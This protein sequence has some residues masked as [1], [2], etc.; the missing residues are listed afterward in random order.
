MS[1]SDMSTTQNSG[2][3][4]GHLAPDDQLVLPQSYADMAS[5]HAL[6]AHFRAHDPIHWTK[7]QMFRPFWSLFR[8]GDILEIEKRHDIFLNA[9]R[10]Q[11]TSIESEDMVMRV[12]GGSHILLRT[13]VHMDDPDHARFRLLTQSWFMP[14]NLK[15]LEA[16]IADMAREHVRHMRDLG[17]A[18]DFVREVAV[19]YPLRVIMH[20]MGLP[21]EDEPQMLR[22]TQ[23]IF[24]P[25]D[26]DLRRDDSSE[27]ILATVQELFTYFNAI[28][29]D[30]RQNP[31]DDVCS[32]IANAQVDNAP[33]GHL[34]AMSY[35]III[36][37]A[38]HDTTSST[39][40]GGLAALIDHPEQLTRLQAE[41]DLLPNAV[42]EMFR[43]VTPVRHF[44]RTA[45][46]D[47]PL[48]D[49][50]IR[51]GDALCL[52]YPSA[53]RDETVFS[54]PDMFKIDRPNLKHLAFGHGAH[55]CLG[56]HLARMEIKALFRELLPQIR[57]IESSGPR[58]ET[59]SNFVGG[60][61]SLPI[62]IQWQ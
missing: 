24:A 39:T 4:E 14:P 55:I 5:L 48:R 2:S 44:M 8:H 45:T 36:A 17:D 25:T 7:P 58:Q 50:W 38:G 33:I 57:S 35:Y 15:R 41:P 26:P 21:P 31:R 22:L 49:K 47:Y 42:E 28:T 20:V 12:T 56:M 23:E 62:R 11:L 19:Y 59:A 34:E 10:T 60:L 51:A 18:C 30:R 46:Q 13:L 6:F 16:R 3:G 29:E 27:A 37:T 53:N 9:P 1:P 54:D 52:Y 40:A 61:K 43:L 32:V